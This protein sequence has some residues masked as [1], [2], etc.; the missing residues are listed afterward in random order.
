[1]RKPILCLILLLAVA[2]PTRAYELIFKNQTCAFELLRVLGAAPGGGADIRECLDTASRIQEGDDE[3]WYREWLKT[4]NRVE[5]LADTCAAGGHNVSAAEALLRASSY[6][7]TAEFFLHARPDDPRAL[8]SWKR[9]VA[10]F[11]RFAK[12]KKG[13]PLR[14]AAGGVSE[15]GGEIRTVAIPFE[16]TTL[17]G[18][19]CLVDSK[20]HRPTLL[21][22]TGFDGSAE[23]LYYTVAVF[24]L[25]R[26]YNC[27]IF[28]G[29]GQG[30][31]IRTQKLVFRP[32]WETVV[33][34]VVDFAVRQPEVD[35]KR[36]ALEGRSMGGYLAPRAAAFEHRLKACIANGGVYDFG[37][38]LKAHFPASLREG[39]ATGAADTPLRQGM[40]TN[41]GLRWLLQDGMWKFGATS[42]SQFFRMT[43]TYSLKDCVERITCKMLVVRSE[44]DD[45]L[46]GQE[47]KL[48]D[49]LRCPKELMLF[50]TAE[51]AGEH[52]QEGAQLD[53]SERIL[54]WLDANL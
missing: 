33:T 27:L 6:Y 25:R 39:L 18:Y 43:D 47:Q 10:C 1:M 29:P 54:D 46:P 48:Y 4:A 37:A 24:A 42:P 41:A 28:E 49:A 44:A 11:R 23:E 30:G 50:T 14:G 38:G 7:R 19:L 20:P 2:V 53:S 35:P 34:P 17:P 13:P 40:A 15:G 36:L 16:G 32:N 52:C 5:Q 8:D 3:S 12:L 21:I 26:G 22:C 45:G 31:A 51:G 9:S